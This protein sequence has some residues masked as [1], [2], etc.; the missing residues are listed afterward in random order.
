[1]PK[2]TN[3]ITDE[4]IATILAIKPIPLDEDDEPTMTA[5]EW[6]KELSRLYLVTLLQKGTYIQA[7]KAANVDTGVIT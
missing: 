4:A 7:V 2:I 3:E 5:I 6:M 1:M